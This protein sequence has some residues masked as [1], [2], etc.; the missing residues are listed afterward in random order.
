MVSNIK[1]NKTSYTDKKINL[2]VLKGMPKVDLEKGLDYKVGDRVSHVK[3]GTGVVTEIV[4]GNKDYT[5]SV[6]FDNGESRTLLAAFAKLEKI[7]D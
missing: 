3:F 4:K 5:V 7:S 1:R 6:E 2:D